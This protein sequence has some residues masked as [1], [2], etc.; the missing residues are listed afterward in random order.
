MECIHAGPKSSAINFTTTSLVTWRDPGF[1]LAMNMSFLIWNSR[2]KS[3]CTCHP[4]LGI[5][6]E[7]HTVQHQFFAKVSQTNKHMNQIAHVQP[8]TWWNCWSMSLWFLFHEGIQKPSI[9][10][11]IPYINHQK[12]ARFDPPWPW[13]CPYRWWA[14]LLR[15]LAPR[16]KRGAIFWFSELINLWC[17][18]P[19]NPNL[20][21]EWY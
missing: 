2:L 11:V 9:S 1:D 7:C 3:S 13:F 14:N 19:K 15:H 5:V 21:L 6:S 4:K 12:S 16:R 8:P 10:Q 17:F 20:S 18:I